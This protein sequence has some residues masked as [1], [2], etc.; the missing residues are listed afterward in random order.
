MQS[1]QGGRI[2]LDGKEVVNMASNNYL[3]LAND[4]ALV[5]AAQSAIEQYGVGPGA[6]RGI[7]GNF[8]A[9]NELERELAA[10]KAAEATLA[11]NSGLT[12]NYGLIPT[13]AGKG[14]TVYS[15]ELN[16]ASIIDGIRLSR[17]EVKVFRHLDM[18]SLEEQL[19]QP[20]SGKKL[21]ITDGVFSMDGDLAPLPDM[22]QLCRRYAAR[23]MVDD[24]HGDGVMGR[25]GRGTVEHFGLVGQV[26]VESGSL[27]KAL[28]A[29]GG[30]VAGPAELVEQTRSQAR[31]FI[32]TSS[33]LPPAFAAAALAAVRIL[34][35][36]D[37]RVK[38]LWAN[39]EY[40]MGRLK[41]LGFNT[42]SSKTPIIPVYAHDEE[43]AR[44]LSLRLYEAGVYSQAMTFPIVP[45]GQARLR[46][47]VSAA[48]TREDLDLTV[49]ALAK[50]GRAMKLI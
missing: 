34:A 38:K 24:A 40:F 33:P 17:S 18:N 41:E 3:G 28:G 20:A 6:G 19:R 8:P 25:G 5:R 30:F 44:Q 27:S 15:D 45:R 4:P 2:I 11:F 22:V 35:A 46:V 7:A 49:A 43:A 37:E 29:V 48:H 21:V 14:D 23:L 36:S 47:I 26:D 10:F 31:S 9:H 13:L 50:V 39:R 32:F 1:P 16:H 42:G 12:A